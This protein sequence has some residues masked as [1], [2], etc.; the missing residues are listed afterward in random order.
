MGKIKRLGLLF[1][2][3]LVVSVLSPLCLRRAAAGVYPA[4]VVSLALFPD[5]SRA[6]QW[7]L[8]GGIVIFCILLVVA[9]VLLIRRRR[10]RAVSDELRR[11]YKKIV[12]EER[13]RIMPQDNSETPEEERVVPAPEEAEEEAEEGKE[14]VARDTKP[15]AGLEDGMLT[16]T[17]AALE[18]LRQ[19]LETRN[20]GPASCFRLVVSPLKPG[21]LRMVVDR[22]REGDCIL[23]DGGK[24][25]LLLSPDVA[26]LMRGATLDYKK[27]VISSGFS[28]S[29]VQADH[30]K[31]VENYY[32][33]IT[34]GQ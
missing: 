31:Q 25:I 12:A 26:T 22:D 28:V 33:S 32:K 19:E 14:A 24:R 21:Q 5:A 10:D 20:V 16:V 15:A 17:P 1:T 9:A 34:K 7:W 23:E 27:G 4:G 3:P 29:S 11:M 8:A 18:K 6:W 30:Y 13:R 2:F